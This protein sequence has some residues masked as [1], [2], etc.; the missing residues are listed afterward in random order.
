LRD[1]QIAAVRPDE[2]SPGD[3]ISAL[4]VDSA[5]VLWIGTRANG[6]MRFQNGKW[7]HYTTRQGGLTGNR[8]GYLLDDGANLWLGAIG[9]TRV[10]KKSLN[11]FA[12]GTAGSVIC[13]AYVEADGLPTRECTQGSQPAACR[14]AD[15]RLWFPTTQGVV[16]A[17][18]A[19]G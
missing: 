4:H 1:G 18:P 10:P 17:D 8:I 3:D 11:A 2:S 7:T 12:D 19:A 5:D 15:G 9:L 14:T 6:L 13:R 16:F